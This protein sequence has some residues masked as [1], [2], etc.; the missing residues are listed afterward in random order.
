MPGVTARI[1]WNAEERLIAMTAS[2]FSTGKS[3]IGETCWMPALLTSTSTRPNVFSASE[4]MLAISIGSA[5]FA[6]E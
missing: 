6:G 1:A 3:S 2:H 5:M 4:I